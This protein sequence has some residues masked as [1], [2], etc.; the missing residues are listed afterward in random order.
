MPENRLLPRVHFND[1]RQSQEK[2]EGLLIFEIEGKGVI[3][4][5]EPRLHRMEAH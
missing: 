3:G 2:E 1:L 5:H 4:M